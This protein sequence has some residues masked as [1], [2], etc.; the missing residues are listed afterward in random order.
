MLPKSVTMKRKVGKIKE[1]NVDKQAEWKDNQPTSHSAVVCG[2]RKRANKNKEDHRA[3]GERN[4]N[5][6][7]FCCT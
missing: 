3:I 1:N 7:F 4:C 5:E 2:A 6:M